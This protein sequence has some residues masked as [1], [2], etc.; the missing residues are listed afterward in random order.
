VAPDQKYDY[1]Y[2]NRN[3]YNN[4]NFVGYYLNRTSNHPVLCGWN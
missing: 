3:N 2:E 1:L 4:P